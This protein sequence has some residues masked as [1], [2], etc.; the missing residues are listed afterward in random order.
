MAALVTTTLEVAMT[1]MERARAD[2]EAAALLVGKELAALQ[3]RVLAANAA[4]SVEWN[5]IEA[6]AR[7]RRRL[8]GQPAGQAPIVPAANPDEQ[9]ELAFA[10]HVV[11]AEEVLQSARRAVARLHNEVHGATEPSIPYRWIAPWNCPANHYYFKKPCRIA[12]HKFIQG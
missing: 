10:G 3:D 1:G 8:S 7:K 12:V 11:D 9:T 5:K 6:E 4:V 2:F